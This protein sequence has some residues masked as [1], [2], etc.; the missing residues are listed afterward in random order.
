MFFSHPAMVRYLRLAAYTIGAVAVF[1]LGRFGEGKYLEYQRER[2]VNQN[3]LARTLLG[4][5]RFTGSVG[6]KDGDTEISAYVNKGSPRQ[7]APPM[8]QISRIR[9]MDDKT[10]C[11]TVVDDLFNNESERSS[12]DEGER[13]N[14]LRW[15][16]KRDHLE[17]TLSVEV[18]DQIGAE[19]EIKIINHMNPAAA[20]ALL[21]RK[22]K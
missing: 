3:V 9:R 14:D 17:K 4:E 16:Y 2:A 13:T 6:F 20:Q 22:A 11:Y 19:L 12:F 5:G 15:A 10:E 7:L 21:S 1:A 18:R 8:V